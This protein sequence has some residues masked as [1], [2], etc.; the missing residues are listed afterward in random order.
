M[1]LQPACPGAH[2][3]P[4]F[5]FPI[6]HLEWASQWLYLSKI[7]LLK[8]VRSLPSGLLFQHTPPH[9]EATFLPACSPSRGSS[10]PVLLTLPLCFCPSNLLLAQAQA[11][12]SGQT[13]G[14]GPR[15]SCLFSLHQTPGGGGH[16]RFQGRNRVGEPSMCVGSRKIRAN[17]SLARTWVQG[18]PGA[19]VRAR[20]RLPGRAAGA[21][22]VRTARS[23]AEGWRGEEGRW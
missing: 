12:A 11:Y 5:P 15:S 18:H 20:Q 21:D 6:L 10:P 13:G 1:V 23:P 7:C 17:A 9:P 8:E 19:Q 3:G 2:S 14:L 22:T 16:S 4:L